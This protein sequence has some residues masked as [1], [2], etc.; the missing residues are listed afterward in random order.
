MRLESA[1]NT[2]EEKLERNLPA[3]SSIPPEQI[4]QDEV[5]FPKRKDKILWAGSSIGRNVN[6]RKVE[7]LSSKLIRTRRAYTAVRDGN[8]HFPNRNLQDV[9]REEL[10]QS[11]YKYCVL[12]TGSIE[13]TNSDTKNLMNINELKDKVKSASTD[14][15]NV[16]AEAIK[17]HPNLEKVIIV[18]R[19]PRKDTNAK[20]PYSLKTQLSEYGNNVYRE[21]LEKTNL[22]GKICIGKHDFNGVHDED[23][24]GR[25]DHPRYDGL[26]LAG[27]HGRY[28]YTR[29]LCAILQKAGMISDEFRFQYDEKTRKVFGKQSSNGA[30]TQIQKDGNSRQTNLDTAKGSKVRNPAFQRD[31]DCRQRVK[32]RCKQ[33]FQNQRNQGFRKEK[34][35]KLNNQTETPEQIK[36]QNIFDFFNQSEN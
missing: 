33:D 28:Q 19:A 25:S 36:T 14:V 3:S 16:A 12:A 32:V 21:L 18:D 20:Y 7:H 29:S 13:I 31:G 9:V 6:F 22:K 8:A 34:S 1:V 17:N 10:S 35:R 4:P 15:F 2:C 27:K 23:I 30:Q 5:S 24:F 11:K 26:H